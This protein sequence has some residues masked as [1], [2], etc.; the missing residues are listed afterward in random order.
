MVQSVLI[1][2]TRT[3]PRPA[4]LSKNYTVALNVAPREH[5]LASIRSP[6]ALCERSFTNVLSPVAFTNVLSRTYPGERSLANV[7]S[8]TFPRERCFANVFFSNVFSRSFSRERS[9]A[10]VPLQ[11]FSPPSPFANVPSQTLSRLR[12]ARS[13]HQ[14]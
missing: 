6:G 8:R 4:R 7:I 2:N 14:L 3:R 5:S 12:K 1:C 9:L 11:T 10:N 13:W